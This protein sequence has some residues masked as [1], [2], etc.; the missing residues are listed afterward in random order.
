LVLF[1]SL[2]SVRLEYIFILHFQQGLGWDST[3]WTG[4]AATALA[5]TL[6]ITPGTVQAADVWMTA[7]NAG[8]MRS[9]PK[10]AV[11]VVYVEPLLRV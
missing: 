6:S 11:S 9:G 8:V 1:A 4:T 5:L 2:F 10:P 3:S 7:S